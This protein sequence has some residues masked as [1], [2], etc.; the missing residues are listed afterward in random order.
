MKYLNRILA[1]MNVLLTQV[2]GA[3]IVVCYYLG[4]QYMYGTGYGLHPGLAGALAAVSFLVP[5]FLTEIPELEYDEEEI[6]VRIERGFNV[7]YEEDA[8]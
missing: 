7:N 3:A 4:Y 2:S 8:K 1:L 5:W 6:L